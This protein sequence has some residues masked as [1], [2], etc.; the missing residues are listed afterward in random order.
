MAHCFCLSP[1][2]VVVGLRNGIYVLLASSSFF[3]FLLLRVAPTSTR[4]PS[5]LVPSTSEVPV[6]TRRQQGP[7]PRALGTEEQVEEQGRGF[8]TG[9]RRLQ[10]KE[11]TTC[12]EV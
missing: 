2:V 8:E 1:G 10:R 6:E 3:L 7:S 4:T 9:H 5:A 11:V 12:T